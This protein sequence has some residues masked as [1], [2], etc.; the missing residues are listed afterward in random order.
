MHN[1][2]LKLPKGFVKENGVFVRYYSKKQALF[3]FFISLIFFI[4]GC[5]Y[6]SNKGLGHLGTFFVIPIVFLGLVGIGIAIKILLGKIPA[7]RISSEGI[8]V[9][10][11]IPITTKSVRWDEVSD[12]CIVNCS[13]NGVDIS[14]IQI[15]GAPKETPKTP[16][17]SRLILSNKNKKRNTLQISKQMLGGPLNEFI[18]FVT[19]QLIDHV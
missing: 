4:M 14:Y 17:L 9:I 18:L 11:I 5:L 19:D 10:P 16:M 6:I 2:T 8:S 13:V 12:I 1:S 7:I 3:V 15:T